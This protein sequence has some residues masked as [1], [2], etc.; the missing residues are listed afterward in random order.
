MSRLPRTVSFEEW[1][2]LIHKTDRQDAEL[3]ALR[4]RVAELEG[5]NAELRRKVAILDPDAPYPDTLPAGEPQDAL[6][7]VA[8]TA[9]G[10]GPKP[11]AL[12]GSDDGRS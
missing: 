7:A 8:E 9:A 3:T 12:G 5:D 11:Q 10:K 1:L 4:A 2:S 6:R